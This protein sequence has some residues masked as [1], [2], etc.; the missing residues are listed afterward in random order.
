VNLCTDLGALQC[1]CVME[2]MGMGEQSTDGVNVGRKGA[3]G[4]NEHLIEAP[5]WPGLEPK[6]PAAANLTAGAGAVEAGAPAGEPASGEKRRR[7]PKAE[8][9]TGDPG[10]PAEPGE[11]GASEAPLRFE[12]AVAALEEAVRKLEAG[13]VP[14]EEAMRLFQDGVRLSRR[15]AALLDEAERKMELLLAQEGEAPT[16]KPY[17]MPPGPGRG[18][19][20]A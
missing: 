16:L 2:G 8:A 18:A 11:P 9:G 10:A 19:Q 17:D 7:R 14:L 13:D 12:E 20:G 4:E 5:L 15:C 3:G 1:S 6:A